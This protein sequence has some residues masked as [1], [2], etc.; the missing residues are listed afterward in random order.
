TGSVAANPSDRYY[1][2]SHEIF[3]PANGPTEI[4]LAPRARPGN[5]LP[6]A[7]AGALTVILRLYDPQGLDIESLKTLTL[8]SLES[9]G[10]A[11]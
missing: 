4:V 7:A 3:A 5:W 8:P 1:L 6:T 9:R 10:C 2:S 11:S